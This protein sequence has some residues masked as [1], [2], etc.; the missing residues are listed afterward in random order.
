MGALNTQSLID[1]LYMREDNG[2]CTVSVRVL[3]DVLGPGNYNRF[4][5]LLV[6]YGFR[7]ERSRSYT[8]AIINRPCAEARRIIIDVVNSLIGGKGWGE[9]EATKCEPKAIGEVTSYLSSRVLKL[10][11]S[12]GEAVDDLIINLEAGNHVVLLGGPGSGKTLILDAIAEVANNPLYVNMADASAAGIE[13]LIIEAGCVDYL[14]L[15][16]LDKARNIALSPLLQLLDH[17]GR[18]RITKHGKA[19]SLEMPWLRA[20]A[21]ANPFNPRVRSANWWAPL[22]DRLVPIE[23]PQ[24]SVDELIGFMESITNARM[25]GWVR[26][27]V[28]EYMGRVTLRKAEQAAKYIVKAME[29]GKSE[30]TIKAKVEKIMRSYSE[31]VG[32]LSTS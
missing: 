9:A 20:V 17:G 15:D 26:Q 6:R 12:L 22:M 2:E 30:E 16:E 31:L 4:R 11:P 25:P 27:V 8:W 29:R 32:D 14:L 3:I 21:A 10:V 13:D 5:T 7:I 19:V 23:V 1:G 24:P 28:E 18:L